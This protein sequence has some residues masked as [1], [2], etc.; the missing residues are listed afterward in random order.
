MVSASRRG[1]GNAATFLYPP[2]L[3]EFALGFPFVGAIVIGVGEIAFLE[4]AGFDLAGT[5]GN[6]VFGRDGVAVTELG[7]GLEA[8]GESNGCERHEP[9]RQPKGRNNEPAQR[10]LR[11]AHDSSPEVSSSP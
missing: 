5:G 11:G 2:F 1:F 6:R 7:V 9:C 10:A 8:I 4:A 3:V